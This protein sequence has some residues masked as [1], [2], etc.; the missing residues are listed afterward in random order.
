MSTLKVDNIQSYSGGN[1]TLDNQLI[2]T[3][4]YAL[5]AETALNAGADLSSYTGSIDQT[6]GNVRFNGPLTLTDNTTIQ[7]DP[8]AGQRFINV[9]VSG[10]NQYVIGGFEFGGQA[11]GNIYSEAPGGF[12]ITNA[13]ATGSS[14]L[15]LDSSNG[16]ID[17][18]SNTYTAINSTNGGIFNTMSGNSLWRAT[19]SQYRLTLYG[20]GMGVGPTPGYT[21]SAFGGN[22]DST[23]GMNIYKTT[24]FSQD[25]GMALDLNAAAG[26]GTNKIGIFSNFGG[27]GYGDIMSW[28]DA[29]NYT[30]GRVEIHQILQVDKVLELEPQDPL[31]AGALGQ[32]AVSGSDLYFHNGTSWIVK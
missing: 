32:L 10:S 15:R 11:F 30:D 27:A 14:S 2:G 31:P 7:Y 22:F 3:S 1:I 25:T 5:V 13:A 6:G 16:S 28:E 23:Y 29:N 21:G 26:T 12:N 19:Q 4:S 18:Q 20:G 24:D 17:L 8:V 9:Q